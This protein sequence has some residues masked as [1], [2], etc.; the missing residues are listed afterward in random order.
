MLLANV[1]CVLSIIENTVLV[2]GWY[3]Y[4]YYESFKIFSTILL[5]L[6]RRSHPHSDFLSVIKLNRS[7]ITAVKNN[8]EQYG[9]ASLFHLFP[10][11]LS[12]GMYWTRRKMRSCWQSLFQVMRQVINQLAT[13]SYSLLLPLA[14]FNLRYTLCWGGGTVMSLTVI[15]Y[16]STSKINNNSW[17]EVLK[18]LLID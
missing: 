12:M 16:A 9:L 5:Y 6:H 4:C 14:H 17:T 11:C 2:Q 15:S 7:P 18:E 13:M 3:L 8:Q 10:F 1:L